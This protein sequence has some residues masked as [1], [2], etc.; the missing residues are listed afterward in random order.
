MWSHEDVVELDGGR[1]LDDLLLSSSHVS[2]RDYFRLLLYKDFMTVADNITRCRYNVKQIIKSPV[3]MQTFSLS[4]NI[5][6][7]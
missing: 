3:E 1:Y 2:T 7:V 6:S 4:D 5:S